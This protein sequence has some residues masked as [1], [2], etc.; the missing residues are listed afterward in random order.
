VEFAPVAA[1]ALRNL[2]IVVMALVALCW[3]AL[4]SWIHNHEQRIEQSSTTA[5]SAV[6]PTAQMSRSDVTPVDSACSDTAPAA[7]ASAAAKPAEAMP[8]IPTGEHKPEEC[9]IDVR[10][11]KSTQKILV[12]ARSRRV[13]TRV[14][15]GA[16]EE[17]AY[18]RRPHYK[19]GALIA[20]ES[21]HRPIVHS[22]KLGW[23]VAHLLQ[24]VLESTG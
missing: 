22:M 16:A 20:R 1:L 10:V 9:V 18:P 12:A 11:G 8:R 4:E 6:S 14:L 2:L 19:S 7:T 13:A 21:P 24:T 17:H 5:P 3:L 23:P 15:R